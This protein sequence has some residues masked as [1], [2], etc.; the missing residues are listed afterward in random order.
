MLPA[1]LADKWVCCYNKA[2]VY[3]FMKSYISIYSIYWQTRLLRILSILFSI[4]LSTI[5][6]YY[7]IKILKQIEPDI[8]ALLS[9]PKKEATVI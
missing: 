3:R 2:P 7:I 8:F 6:C 9:P 5:K 1:I 4:K